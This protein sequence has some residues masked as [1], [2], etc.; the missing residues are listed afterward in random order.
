MNTPITSSLKVFL[1]RTILGMFYAFRSIFFPSSREAS[2]LVYHSI[3]DNA[4]P[5]AISPSVFEEHLVFLRRIGYSFVSLDQLVAWMKEG[6]DLARK[7]V[8]ITFDDG[9]AD[10]FTNAYPILLK[11]QVPATIF[12]VAEPKEGYFPNGTTM[13]SSEQMNTMRSSGLVDIQSHSRTHEMLD[14]VS[15]DVL[16]REIARGGYRYLAYP[17]GHLDLSV[18]RAVEQEGYDAAFSIKPGLLHQGD[19]LFT[20]R[21]NVIQNPMSLFDLRIRVSLAMHWYGRLT[22]F[23]KKYHGHI[24]QR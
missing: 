6:K 15:P 21:R 17:G 24:P 2:V 12:L 7:V 14:E 23:L 9:Y 1:K 16:A 3:S 8:A 13:L 11:H 5:L 22:V 4:T 18:M 10:N 19:H 20:L